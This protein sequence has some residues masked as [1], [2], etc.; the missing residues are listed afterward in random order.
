MNGSAM[1]TRHASSNLVPS[2]SFLVPWGL[3]GAKEALDA[4][5]A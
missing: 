3:G 1:T 2:S 5:M 4:F